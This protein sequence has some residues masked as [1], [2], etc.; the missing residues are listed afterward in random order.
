MP[1]KGENIYKRKDGRWEGRYKAG[2]A[3]YRSVYGKTYQDVK[4]RLNALKAAQNTTV[5]SGRMTIKE[6]YEEWLSAVRLKVKDSTLANYRMKAERHILPE[7]G[8]LLYN[9][10]TAS[11][12][13][14]FIDNK[15]NE[16]LSAKYVC[17]II[18][19]LRSATRYASKVHGYP[20]RLAD[21]TLPK[22]TRKEPELLDNRQQAELCRYLKN[23][24]DTTAMCI[25]LSL[26]AGLRI[27]EVC[28]LMW[29]DIDFEKRTLTVRRTV[30]RIAAQNGGTKLMIGTP[31]SQT[32]CRTIPLPPFMMK[33]LTD[34]YGRGYVLTGTYTPVEPRTL[35]QRF[36]TILKK[37]GLPKVTYHSLRHA[38]ATNCVRAGFDV[39]T[40]SEILGHASVS[41]TL[42]RYVHSSMEQ[43][44]HCMELLRFA[45]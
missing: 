43:K 41:T 10:L 30:Q 32:S 42:N 2:T 19:V 16:G 4:Q 22:I 20:D 6:L 38:F 5:S 8:E 39:K 14:I 15:L 36:S 27:G 33:I 35:Q 44:T 34:F 17:D 18:A 3:K 28:G 45:V 29:E 31:K 23:H 40:L 12:V 9:K 1:R 37:A 24:T 11:A 13:H 21:I 7:F 26:Y 25:L